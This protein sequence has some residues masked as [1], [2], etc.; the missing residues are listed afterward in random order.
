M[1]S[2][3]PDSS[4]GCLLPYACPGGLDSDNVPNQQVLTALRTLQC[5]V[6][7]VSRDALDAALS[8][9]L[10][11]LRK[12]VNHNSLD[13]RKATLSVLTKL[14]FV[15]GDQLDLSGVSDRNRRA[16]LEK[17]ICGRM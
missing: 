9:L 7:R 17:C 5:L 16:I 14:H 2:S 3:N 15:L 10:S 4:F 11:L 8:Q 1:S 12:A 6:D 13:M